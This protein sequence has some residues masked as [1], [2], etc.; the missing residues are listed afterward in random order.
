L[1]YHYKAQGWECVWL[2]RREEDIR[3]MTETVITLWNGSKTKV[4]C[5]TVAPLQTTV[6]HQ[7]QRKQKQWDLYNKKKE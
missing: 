6:H 4:K 3:C 2:C 5:K 7:A 1:G